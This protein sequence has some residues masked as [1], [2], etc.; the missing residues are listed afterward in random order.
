MIQFIKYYNVLV[1]GGGVAGT[2]AAIQAARAGMY[3]GLVEKTILTGGLATAGLINIYLPLCDGQGHQVIYGLAQELLHLS[4]K[5][6]PGNVPAD[7]PGG[8]PELSGRYRTVFSPAS[9]TL[10]LDEALTQARVSLWLDTLACLPVC[11]ENRIIG[12]EV[13]NKSGRGLIYADCV[14]DASGDADIAARAGAPWADGRNWLS[15]WALEASLQA[16]RRAVEGETRDDAERAP[17]LS[18]VRLGAAADGSNAVSNSPQWIGF[19]GAHVSYFVLEGRRL[20]REHYQKLHAQGGD[21]S[22]HHR[23]PLT[24]PAMA[25]FRTSRRIDGQE[26]MHSGQNNIHVPSSIGLAPD[27]RRAGPVWEIPYGALLPRQVSG[28]LV[29]G[30]CISA[31]DDAWEVTRVIPVAALTGQVAGLAAAMAVQ[32]NT[33]PDRLDVGDVQQAL[34]KMS[35]PCHIEELG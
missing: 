12:V 13:E 23:F 29:A 31:A 11:E 30:R 6:G 5:Y 15:V 24:L 2:A 9:F 10:A 1:I 17:L 16:A 28:L 22:R 27:W 18:E 4:I 21:T 33:T 20:L 34:K 8:V 14:I 35:M 7:W 32:Q 26:T 25:Q 19:V 3:T